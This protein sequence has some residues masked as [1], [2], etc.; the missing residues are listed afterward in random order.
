MEKVLKITS[1]KEKQ[2]DYSYWLTK[3]PLELLA[4]I[5]FLRQQF[6]EHKNE[7]QPGLQR[8]CKVINKNDPTQ[9]S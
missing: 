9:K 3:S 7:F 8:V 5:E 2:S 6:I 1:V 4:A